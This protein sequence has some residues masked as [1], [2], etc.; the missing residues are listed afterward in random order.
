MAVPKKRTSKS[1]QRKRRAQIRL[2]KPNIIT[3]PNCS[4]ETLPHIVCPFCGYYK[5][6][7]YTDVLE[8]LDKKERKKREK[9][10]KSKKEMEKEEAKEKK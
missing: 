7:K 8:K 3:C 5:G 9:E 1:R 2:K 4:H 6:K 10:L